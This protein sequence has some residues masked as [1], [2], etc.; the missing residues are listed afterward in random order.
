MFK[1]IEGLPGNVLGFEASGKL[2]HEDYTKKLVPMCEE[3]MESQEKARF[4]IVLGPEF[5]GMELAAL[6]D[7]ASFGIKHWNDISH[8]ALVTEENW[9]RAGAA[10]F[11]P[12]F[13]GVVRIFGLSEMEHAREWISEDHSQQAA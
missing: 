13:P 2:T 5:D 11:A 1:V 12:L 3:F 7:D 9:M 6:W 4:L 10:L 8:I